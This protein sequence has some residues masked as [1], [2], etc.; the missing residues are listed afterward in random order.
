MPILFNNIGLNYVASGVVTINRVV[1]EIPSHPEQPVDFAFNT[2]NGT[3]IVT[4]FY[5]RQARSYTAMNSEQTTRSREDEQTPL[6]TGSQQDDA[7]HGYR[8]GL[9]DQRP[10]KY[11]VILLLSL[12]LTC[13]FVGASI[14]VVPLNSLADDYLCRKMFPS[15]PDG[16]KGD[17]AERDAVSAEF[18]DIDAWSLTFTLLPSLLSSIPFGVLA[19][20]IGR[21][22]PFFLNVIGLTLSTW[23]SVFI[24]CNLDCIDVRWLWASGLWLVIGGGLPVMTATI[25]AFVSDITDPETRSQTFFFLGTLFISASIAGPFIAYFTIRAG[26]WFSI[27]LGLAFITL[28]IPLA[29]FLPE[30]RVPSS[31]KTPGDETGKSAIL[32]QIRTV[33]RETGRV[34]RYQFLENTALGLSLFSLIFTTLGRSLPVV[35]EK[36]ANR[37]YGLSWAEVGLLGSVRSF[38]ALGTTAVVLPLVDVLLR[39]KLNI[40]L[41]AKDMW[42]VRGSILIMLLGSICVGLSKSTVM[43]VSSLAV[44][45][46]GSGYEYAMR[47]LLA[48]IAGDSIATVYTTMS[49]METIGELIAGPMLARLYRVGLGWGGDWI[50]LPLFAI[51]GLFTIAAIIVWFIRLPDNSEEQ[52][53]GQDS[54]LGQA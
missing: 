2:S 50:G 29:W 17:P 54:D 4:F 28:T 34:A 48:Q 26:L 33:C 32:Q 45:G 11:K 21:R 14:F 15:S 47:G 3:T 30:T 35:V 44:F 43:F 27:W 7:T 37:R 31:S 9:E 41:A 18:A 8:F 36:Y 23:Y 6:L 19:D 16:C 12:I 51:A 5:K 49:L 10:P 1:A 24:V 42:L 53:V 40:S 13:Y 25:Y 22:I 46:L 20:K 38:V 52:D 39:K